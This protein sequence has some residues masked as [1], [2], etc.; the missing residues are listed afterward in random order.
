MKDQL[1]DFLKQAVELN[2]NRLPNI[3]FMRHLKRQL[4]K[5]VTDFGYRPGSHKTIID[6]ILGN[7]SIDFSALGRE[8]SEEHDEYLLE[9]AILT[10]KCM[11]R[12][13][14]EISDDLGHDVFIEQV[15][16]F[17]LSLT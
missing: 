2:L 13:Y 8:C 17:S 7:M 12:I 4:E 15:K 11:W 1:L 6:T 3:V 5:Q 16:N 9:I 14:D 10:A